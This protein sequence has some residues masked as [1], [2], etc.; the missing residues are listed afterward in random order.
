MLSRFLHDTHHQAAGSS[1]WCADP[2][3]VVAAG[4]LLQLD[5]R[6]RSAVDCGPTSKD[7]LLQDTATVVKRFVEL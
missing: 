4:R 5:G 3:L 7:T 6:R 2:V 1:H